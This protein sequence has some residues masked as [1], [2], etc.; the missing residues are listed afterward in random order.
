MLLLCCLL[1]AFANASM[2][3][4]FE[5]RRRAA[6]VAAVFVLPAFDYAGYKWFQPNDNTMKMVII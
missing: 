2:H 6:V 3:V 4:A 1:F 5:K